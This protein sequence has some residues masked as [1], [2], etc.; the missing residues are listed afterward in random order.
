M[1]L[2]RWNPEA[3]LTKTFVQKK[4]FLFNEWTQSTQKVKY[5]SCEHV[6]ES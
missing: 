4:F 1:S 3:G 2:E 5:C 6:P